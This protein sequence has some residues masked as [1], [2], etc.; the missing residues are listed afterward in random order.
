MESANQGL[1]LM[2]FAIPK[3]IVLA[4]HFVLLGYK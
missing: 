4:Y 3:S 2:E 1:D